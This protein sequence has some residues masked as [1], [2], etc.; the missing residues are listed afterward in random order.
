MLVSI[1]RNQV[2]LT[3]TFSTKSMSLV[4]ADEIFLPSFNS[5]CFY[6]FFFLTCLS[7]SFRYCILS[8]NIGH[9]L[10]LLLQLRRAL[11]TRIIFH[12]LCT[13]FKMI[14]KFFSDFELDHR[15]CLCDSKKMISLSRVLP[16]R[17][18]VLNILPIV[19]CL[20][21]QYVNT[22]YRE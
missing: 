3:W 11:L 16:L 20:R 8:I 14:L 7:H 5:F 19:T 10:L 12:D 1:K 15:L 22:I 13:F 4:L 9:L 17:P 2:C 21:V 6:S 18:W